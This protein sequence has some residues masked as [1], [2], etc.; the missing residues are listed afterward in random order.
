M[1]FTSFG[2]KSQEFDLS[3]RGYNKDQVKTFLEKLAAEF[4]KL[5]SENEQLKEDKKELKNRLTEFKKI[6]K[7][8]QKTL[9]KA[10]ES[11]SKTIEDTK[12]QTA[13]MIKEAEFK[14]EQI[15][16]K[17][18]EYAKFIRDSVS[19]LKEEKEL[20]IARLKAMIETQIELLELKV[21]K[22]PEP[23]AVDNTAKRDENIEIEN[24]QINIDDIM[25]KLI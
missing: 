18:N 3:L 24:T 13:L 11:S 25:E 6:E 1:K 9:I 8:L 4:E 21:E 15:I 17:A 2:I 7:N 20:L 22:N 23:K 10:Q 14:S 5:A 16:N 19:I 12:K